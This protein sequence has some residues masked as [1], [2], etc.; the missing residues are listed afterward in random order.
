V[1]IKP[2]IQDN[3]ECGLSTKQLEEI[4]SVKCWGII[5]EVEFDS[6]KSL[7]I[8]IIA[9]LEYILLHKKSRVFKGYRE[10]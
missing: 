8:I 6:K 9:S 7:D 2:K 1:P 3:S 4:T 10:G 5:R